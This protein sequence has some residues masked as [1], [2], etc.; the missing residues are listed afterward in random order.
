MSLG[1]VILELM[2][3]R[4]GFTLVELL[5]VITIIGILSAI[6]MS[7]FN[8]AQNRAKDAKRKGD[9]DSVAKV[10]EGK[11]NESTFSY[12]AP[13]AADFNNSKPPVPPEGGNYSAKVCKKTSD[14]KAYKI[15]AKL[16]GSS[17][18]CYTDSSDLT[19]CYCRTSAFGSMSD[20]ST[21][22]ISSLTI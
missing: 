11:Y 18:D 2:P 13:A 16:G 15:C 9:V 1:C 3:K 21:D 4:S 22:E 12:L 14:I 10:F 5:V 20:C 17:Q 19:K 7:G 6:G 8:N